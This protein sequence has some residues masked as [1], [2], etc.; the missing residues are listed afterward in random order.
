MEMSQGLSES[1]GAPTRKEVEKSEG[2]ERIPRDCLLRREESRSPHFPTRRSGMIS[3]RE[4]EAT[5]LGEVPVF[6]LHTLWR[7]GE[8]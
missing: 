3:H 1:L 7:V 4:L 6:P 5:G 2:K 8:N